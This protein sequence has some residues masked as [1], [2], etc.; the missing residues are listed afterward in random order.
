[1]LPKITIPSLR[2]AIER[3]DI[4]VIA[5]G[6]FALQ[7]LQ[8]SLKHEIEG[9]LPKM[10]QHN[11]VQED[12]RHWRRYY[13]LLVVHTSSGFR[14]GV[15]HLHEGKVDKGEN[16]ARKVVKLLV[17]SLTAK[18]A[19]ELQH[20]QTLDHWMQ[21][22]IVV[23]QGLASGTSNMQEHSADGKDQNSQTLH[24]RT[25]KWIVSN[26]LTGAWFDD[27]S[28]TCHGVGLIAGSPERRMAGMAKDDVSEAMKQ[29]D[30]DDP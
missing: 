22:Q 25:A 2:G 7:H 30:L 23:F 1:M 6:G 4:S 10:T 14:L 11:V 8:E 17:D 21:D 18:L 13:A 16:G 12:S 19:G 29:L 3:I 9:I 28:E 26:I 20:E 5:P 24:T 15:D 27:Q